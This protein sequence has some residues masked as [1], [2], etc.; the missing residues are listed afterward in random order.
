M[1]GQGV[2]PRGD[3]ATWAGVAA[4][5]A[6]TSVGGL[7][8]SPRKGGPSREAPG[9]AYMVPRSSQTSSVVDDGWR[10]RLQIH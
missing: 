2:S 9:S 1:S 10:R 6:T 7:V 8:T 4:S 5:P 3:G